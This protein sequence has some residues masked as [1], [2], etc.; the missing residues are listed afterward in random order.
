MNATVVVDA[1]AFPPLENT[2]EVSL[3]KGSSG[4]CSTHALAHRRRRGGFGTFFVLDRLVV[5]GL[6]CWLRLL[7]KLSR[8]PSEPN[9]IVLWPRRSNIFHLIRT[10]S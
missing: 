4:I 6:V 3:H 9:R 7:W 8:A 5:G 1:I 10:S 2:D